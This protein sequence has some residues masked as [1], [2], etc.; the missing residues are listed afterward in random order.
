MLKYLVSCSKYESVDVYVVCGIWI[1]TS[2][3]VFCDR[4]DLVHV[5]HVMCVVSGPPPKVFL[6][7]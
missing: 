5:D 3:S 4:K 7:G 6:H 2:A 1:Q